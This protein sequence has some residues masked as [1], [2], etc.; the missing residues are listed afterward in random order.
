MKISGIL[1]RFVVAGAALAFSTG[2]V[3]AAPTAGKA[4]VTA[5]KGTVTI[6]N[7]PAKVGDQVGIG[8]QIVTGAGSSAELDLGPNGPSLQ[9]QQ[10]ATVILDE[11]SFDDAGPEVVANTKIN[12]QAGKVAGYVKKTS[13]Q[14]TYTVVTPT[15]TAA[16]RGTTYMVAAEGDVYVW[17]GCVDVRF[18]G[19]RYN[20]C[21]GQHFD[22][23]IPGVVPNTLPTPLP[24]RAQSA[25][26][27]VGPIINLSPVKPEAGAPTPQ[28][29]E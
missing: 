9:I 17:D 8:T 19:A 1:S 4:E 20:V 15:T 16:I 12:L 6:G 25:V 11:L 22:P 29:T 27:P 10:G 24:P 5:I 26:S 23:R 7:Q 21:A 2:L 14:S 13:F 3:S 28:I 18:G